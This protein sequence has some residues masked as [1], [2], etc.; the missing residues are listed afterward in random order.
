MES[1]QAGNISVLHAS[2]RGIHQPK[3]ANALI[4]R[5]LED[6]KHVFFVKRFE[7]PFRMFLR[8]FGCRFF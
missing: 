1:W 7:I 8:A 4:F 2:T 3:L 6:I 5:Q